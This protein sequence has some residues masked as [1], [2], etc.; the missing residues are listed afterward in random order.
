M[1]PVPDRSTIAQVLAFP[2]VSPGR[3]I[4][5]ERHRTVLLIG[6]LTG[7]H[8][9]GPCRIRKVSRYGMMLECAM[10]LSSSDWLRVDLRNGQSVSGRIRWRVRQ[11]VGLALNY[12]LDDVEQW[13]ATV[14]HDGRDGDGFRPRAPRFGCSCPADLFVGDQRIDAALHN[15]SQGGAGL[16]TTIDLPPGTAV[17]LSLPGLSAPLAAHI[18]WCRDHDL[19]VAFNTPLGFDTLAAWLDDPALRYARA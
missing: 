15:V 9:D 17:R 2:R 8:A 1:I 10:A 5:L 18:C 6:H 12:P 3:T 11:R 13:L 16:S 7:P 19:G 4:W 14:T